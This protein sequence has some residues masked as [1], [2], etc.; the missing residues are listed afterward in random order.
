MDAILNDL[1]LALDTL[2]EVKIG[3]VKNG[4]IL[5]IHKDFSGV[6]RLYQI[7]G[8]VYEVINDI[9]FKLFPDEIPWGSQSVFRAWQNVFNTN[10]YP[11]FYKALY[12]YYQEKKV[13]DDLYKLKLLTDEAEL[14]Y[15]NLI[16]A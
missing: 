2:Q 16:A 5:D 12:K 6:N 10:L 11:V 4:K 8:E 14:Y 9:F 1:K 13:Y 3:M 7:N 15:N